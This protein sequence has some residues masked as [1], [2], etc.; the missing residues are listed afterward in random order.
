MSFKNVIKN[1]WLNKIIGRRG[2]SN[3]K[4]QS[5]DNR[6]SFRESESIQEEISKMLNQFYILTP[7]LTKE[8]LDEYH[9]PRYDRLQQDGP[10]VYGYALTVGPDGRPQV[11]EFGNDMSFAH[12]GLDKENAGMDSSVFGK[13]WG[14][15]GPDAPKTPTEREPVADV[16]S[17]DREVKVVME[18]PGVKEEDIAINAC[19]GKLEVLTNTPHR[20]YRKLIELPQ[21][22]DTETARFKHN[23]GVLEV[24]FKRKRT[25]KPKG[26]EIAIE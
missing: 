9:V 7:N 25:A 5:H 6:D 23:N 14:E 4:T 18:M 21:E 1:S 19:D 2:E 10:T 16:N 11:L 8:T 15:S 13:Y 3:K 12:E 26:K 22:A 17:T 20:N 24:T